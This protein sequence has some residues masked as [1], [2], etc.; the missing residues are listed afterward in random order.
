MD[1]T[2]IIS[3]QV[4]TFVVGIVGELFFVNIQLSWT[5]IFPFLKESGSELLEKLEPPCVFGDVTGQITG[6][7]F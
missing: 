3:N 4:G 7:Y 1:E 5:Q 2:S 6:V